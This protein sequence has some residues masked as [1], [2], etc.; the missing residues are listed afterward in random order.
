MFYYITILISLLRVYR[1]KLSC[2]IS[3]CKDRCAGLQHFN[4]C[5]MFI[6]SKMFCSQISS[7]VFVH[8]KNTFVRCFIIVIVI[9]LLRY[10]K[11]SSCA[12]NMCKINFSDYGRLAYWEIIITGEECFTFDRRVLVLY[13]IKVTIPETI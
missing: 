9:S 10:K 12:I 2:A 7:S 6:L 8:V 13:Y 3:I 4:V 5:R 1:K 11:M